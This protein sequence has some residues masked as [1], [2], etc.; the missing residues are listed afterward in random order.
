[1]HFSFCYKPYE[2][3]TVKKLANCLICK[4]EIKY[5]EIKNLKGSISSK[6]TNKNLFIKMSRLT[7]KPKN[8]LTIKKSWNKCYKSSEK[9]QS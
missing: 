4:Y 1:M 9:A 8:K 3:Y 2:V 5:D 7:L 6:Y